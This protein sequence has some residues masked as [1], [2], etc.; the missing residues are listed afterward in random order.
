MRESVAPWE[1]GAGPPHP[2]CPVC[3]S[4]HHHQGFHFCS[5]VPCEV[6]CTGGGQG[7]HEDRLRARGLAVADLAHY[8][9]G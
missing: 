5:G 9:I 4:G 1:E 2:H 3:A 8:T 7:R 6:T